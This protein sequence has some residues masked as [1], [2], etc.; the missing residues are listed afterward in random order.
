M[1]TLSI[2]RTFGNARFHVWA[3]RRGAGI[4]LGRVEAQVYVYAA[5]PSPGEDR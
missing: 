2:P 3:S 1:P 4:R 5:S